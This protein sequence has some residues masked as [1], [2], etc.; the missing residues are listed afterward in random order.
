M[1]DDLEH[2]L[3]QLMKRFVKKTLLKNANSVAKLVKIDVTSKD[4][5]SSYKEASQL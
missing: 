1:Y 5:R 2:L 4:N 3:R